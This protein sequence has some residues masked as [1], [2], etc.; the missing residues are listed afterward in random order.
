[1]VYCSSL[2]ALFVSH[3]SY[4]TFYKFDYQ[5]HMAAAV[6]AGK[7][8]SWHGVKGCGLMGGFSGGCDQ[9]ST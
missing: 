1:M 5:L 7:M 9:P 4:L 8:I 3:V 2:L 6:L